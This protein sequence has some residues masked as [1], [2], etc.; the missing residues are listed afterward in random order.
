MYSAHVFVALLSVAGPVWGEAVHRRGD[1]RRSNR[2]TA[3]RI[4]PSLVPMMGFISRMFGLHNTLRHHH[5]P[6]TT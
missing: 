1:F 2:V 4:V 5:L 3:V 6:S